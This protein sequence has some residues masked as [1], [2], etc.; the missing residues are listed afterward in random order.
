MVRDFFQHLWRGLD[1]TGHRHV[2]VSSALQT[3]AY[4]RLICIH[5]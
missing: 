3:V 5:E 2:S 1:D 4:D